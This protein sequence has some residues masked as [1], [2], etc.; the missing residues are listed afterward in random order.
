MDA[1]VVGLS[2][3]PGCRRNLKPLRNERFN[4]KKAVLSMRREMML[5]SLL[6]GIAEDIPFCVCVSFNACPARTMTCKCKCMHGFISTWIVS[7]AC[8]HTFLLVLKPRSV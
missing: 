3:G 4:E 1:S 7:R 8:T 5:N 2:N 6:V